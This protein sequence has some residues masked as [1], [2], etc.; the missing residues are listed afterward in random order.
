MP[1]AAPAIAAIVVNWNRREDTLR[2]LAS[3]IETD[4]PALTIFLVDN[5]S[6]DGSCEAVRL[7]FPSVRLLESK[8]NLGFAEGNNVALRQALNEGFPFVLLLNNDATI[9]P[10]AI[11]LLLQPLLHDPQVGLSGPAICYTDEP[12]RIWSAGGAID[13]RQGSAKSPWLDRSL[14]SLPKQPFAVDHLSGCAM[15]IRSE[16]IARAGLLDSRFFMYYEETEWCVRFARHGYRLLVV[17]TARVWHAISPHAQSGSPAIA[18]YMTRNQLLFLRATH[19]PPRAWSATLYRQFRT[20]A[21]LFLTHH[22]PERVRGRWPMVLALRDF[23][24]GRFGP[25]TLPRMLH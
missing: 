24:L 5:A 1:G 11:H 10:E 20:L 13:W 7:G 17:P 25:T 2:C 16:A 3:L 14:L 4:Y 23:A 12:D 22:S 6:T 18:Y 9:A 8:T 21:S 15:L 19:A